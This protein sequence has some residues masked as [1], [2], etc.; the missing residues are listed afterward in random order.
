MFFIMAALAEK[1][2]VIKVVCDCWIM[3]VV[4]VEMD[5]VMYYV[6]R[7]DDALGLAALT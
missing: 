4:F 1:F 6:S 3:Y 7:S 2:Q 5:L